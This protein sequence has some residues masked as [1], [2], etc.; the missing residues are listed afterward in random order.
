MTQVTMPRGHSSAPPPAARARSERP[1]EVAQRP[2]DFGIIRRLYACTR[3]YGRLRATLL[4]LVVLR[5]IQLPTI[6]WLIA[7][8][9]SGPIAAHDLSGV[10]LGVAGFLAWTGF[11]AYC[12]VFRSRLAL[13]LGEAVVSDLR[14]QI[15]QH[16]LRLPIS[17]FKRTE[18]GRLIGRVVHD[19]DSV[20]VGVQDVFFVSVVQCGSM[21]ISA[22]LMAYYDWPLFLVVLAMA[23]GL[24]GV[25]R[26]FRKKSSAAYRERSESFARVT[27]SLAESVNGIREIQSFARQEHNARSFA[28][29]IDQHAQVNMYSHRLGAVFQPVLSF[30]GQLFLALLLV[31]GGYQVLGGPSTLG[32]KVELES[33]IQFLFLSTSFF[34]GIPIVGEQ[35]NQALTAMA[36]A[37]RVFRL[38]DTR[39]DWEDA[40]GARDFERIEGHVELSNVSFEYDPGRPVLFDIDFVAQPGQAIALVGHTGS[41]KSTIANL[42]AKL[43]LPSAGQVR[44]DGHDLS[45]MTS[46][47]LHRQIACVTQQNFLF[48]GSVLENIRLGRP[49]ATREQVLVALERLGVTDIIMSLPDGLDSRVGERGVG[50]SL[51]QRQLVCFAR[52]MI[53]DPRVV[54]L[55]EATSSVDS[56]TEARVQEALLRLLAGR[57]SFVV[58][59]RLSTIVHADQVLVLDQGRIIERGTH[60]ELLELGGVYEALYREFVSAQALVA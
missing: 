49:D 42:I 29:L 27:A 48:S 2:L 1:S 51:G 24:W 52:A 35:Y 47:S 41:G 43:Y 11:T 26:Y 12:F 44:I 8:V 10:A 32:G 59:H 14:Y 45:N 4:V 5:S 56:V 34:N 57:T 21:L 30:N 18:I 6:S 19:V 39:P 13:Q 3:R 22:G 25:T 9:I 28:R 20:R 36:G 17:Y 15:Y 7:W 55:D 37:E 53:A 54:I 38:L 16:L 58:A 40:P 50:L 23:P 31:L 46:E 33:L 60:T